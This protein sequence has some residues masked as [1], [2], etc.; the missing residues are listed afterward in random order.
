MRTGTVEESND[1]VC[2]SV[3]DR[4]WM[5]MCPACESGHLFDQRWTFNG[6]KV[7]PTFT[8]SML[9][10]GHLGADNYGV[11]H[12]YVTDGQ[13]QFLGDCTHALAGKTVPLEAF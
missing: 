8:P 7:R 4:G 6:N 1:R 11:C 13:I 2:R 5:I 10:K 9:V 12:S 3:V